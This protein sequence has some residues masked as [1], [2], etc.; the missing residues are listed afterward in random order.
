MGHK[1][2]NKWIALLK[3]VAIF[4]SIVFIVNTCSDQDSSTNSTNKIDSHFSKF[5]GSFIKFRE[6]I[7]ENLNDPSS[8]E[9]V[10]TRFT[11]HEDGT[12]TVWMKY[13]GKN[14]FNATITKIAKCT[15]NTITGDFSNVIT[16]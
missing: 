3:L 10:E 7:K 16:E 11:D 8:F 5:D 14:S 6:Y 4:V 9:H 2:D 1:K 12:A 13:R 15:L